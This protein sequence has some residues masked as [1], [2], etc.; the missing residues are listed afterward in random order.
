MV[1]QALVV[2]SAAIVLLLGSTH[3]IYTFFG[4]KLKPR[5]PTLQTRMSEVPLVLSR[6]TTVWKAWIGFNASHSLGIILFGTVYA[7][8]AVAYPAVLF[9]SKLLVVLGGVFLL[10]YVILAK[11][12]WFRVPFAGV[13]L[14]FV[15]YVAG[16]SVAWT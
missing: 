12:Y 6:E 2:F 9:Q 7:Y 3:L 13:V 11:L 8:L 4:S 15:S 10:A 16:I 5:D 1:A 14:A